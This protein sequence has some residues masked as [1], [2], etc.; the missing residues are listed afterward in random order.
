KDNG[1]SLVHPGHKHRD[2]VVIDANAVEGARFAGS[3]GSDPV[4]C[5]IDH[6]SLCASVCRPGE[7]ETGQPASRAP[8]RKRASMDCKNLHRWHGSFSYLNLAGKE[9]EGI[10]RGHAIYISGCF[11]GGCP[12][13]SGHG[14]VSRFLTGCIGLE[15][16]SN[17]SLTVPQKQD[18][19]R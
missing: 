17:R 13:S 5:K 1:V 3:T 10:G 19:A 8:A 9:Y 16:I 2:I 7:D 11:H 4:L 14:S 18:R 12:S 15:R 6:L